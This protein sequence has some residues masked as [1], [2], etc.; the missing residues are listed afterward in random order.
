MNEID[1]NLVTIAVERRVIKTDVIVI[2]EKPYY[3]IH[4]DA[5]RKLGTT[6][7]K[8]RKMMNG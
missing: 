1:L 8:Y 6:R 3:D 4:P 7:K 2:N 5:A